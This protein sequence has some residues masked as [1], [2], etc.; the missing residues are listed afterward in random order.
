MLFYVFMFIQL[1][2]V[3]SI[4][5]EMACKIPMCNIKLVVVGRLWKLKESLAWI[6]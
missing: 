5:V 3:K 6:S 2:I 1:P 4:S